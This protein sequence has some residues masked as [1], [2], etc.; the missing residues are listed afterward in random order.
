[1]QSVMKK[2][3]SLWSHVVAAARDYESARAAHAAERALLS[4]DAR[5]LR[6]IGIESYQPG[7]AERIHE[8]RRLDAARSRATLGQL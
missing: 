6:D 5:T 4:L 7:L 3:A 2:L 1:M 8:S